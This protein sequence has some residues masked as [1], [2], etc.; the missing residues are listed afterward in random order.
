[1]R[2]M[3]FVFSWG[4][5]ILLESYDLIL[6]PIIFPGQIP[7]QTMLSSFSLFSL[8][9]Y[10]LRHMKISVSIKLPTLEYHYKLKHEKEMIF[11]LVSDPFDLS[12]EGNI[13]FTL[14]A[15]ERGE[16]IVDM[17]PSI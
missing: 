3:C 12:L 6:D 15:Q 10:L 4:S 1:M 8:F 17:Y 13:K 7:L 9:F 14:F 5:S 2:S 11:A 16:S